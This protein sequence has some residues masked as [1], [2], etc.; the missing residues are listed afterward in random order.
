MEALRQLDE[1]FP[2]NGTLSLLIAG[3][4]FKRANENHS[5]DRA[6]TGAINDNSNDCKRDMCHTGSYIRPGRGLDLFCNSVNVTN[7]G[8]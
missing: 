7:A 3:M 4:K 1:G 5:Y 8:L 2:K 6:G